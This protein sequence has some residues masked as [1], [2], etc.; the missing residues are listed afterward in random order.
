M[1][2]EPQTRKYQTQ[3]DVLALDQ[4]NGLYANLKMYEAAA[5]LMKKIGSRLKKDTVD[6]GK[7]TLNGLER[8]CNALAD[9]Y[10]RGRERLGIG[11]GTVFESTDYETPMYHLAKKKGGKSHGRPKSNKQ[12]AEELKKKRRI[13]EDKKR[14]K[15]R[16]Y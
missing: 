8:T 1:Y 14:R 12:K 13:K 11:Y 10:K 6:L 15:E 9:F 5:D 16:G 4:T 3:A 2:K 7:V